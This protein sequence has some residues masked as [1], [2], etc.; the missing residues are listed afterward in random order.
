[1]SKSLPCR[2]S[3]EH[4]RVLLAVMPMFA[5][6]TLAPTVAHAQSTTFNVPFISDFGCSVVKWMKGPLAV[7]IFVIVIF[8]TLVIGMIAKMDWAKIVSIA[9]IF[10]LITALGG[11]LANNQYM[12]GMAGLSGC[13]Q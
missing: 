8:A 2:P 6:V 4:F 11:F 1:M 7:L 9:V 12:Q 3:I 5:I 13:L 10:G